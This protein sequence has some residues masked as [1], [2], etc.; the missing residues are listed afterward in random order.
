MER[1]IRELVSIY[2]SGPLV[3][4][5][6]IDKK[7][8]Q[9]RPFHT[10]TSCF[11]QKGEKLW[12]HPFASPLSP[13]IHLLLRMQGRLGNALEEVLGVV[14]PS[15]AKL[16]PVRHVW[17]DF[18]HECRKMRW[19]N[20]AKLVDLIATDLDEQGKQGSLK[21]VGRERLCGAETHAPWLCII[22]TQASSTRRAAAAC[23]RRSAG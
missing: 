4:V 13:L 2:G 5:N 23:A 19:G 6:L 7:K 3:L 9:V 11:S 16:C 10:R 22:S 21:M 20:L 15:F 8:D 14:S 12:F 1:H 18:H 17:F